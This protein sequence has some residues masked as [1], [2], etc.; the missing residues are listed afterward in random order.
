MLYVRFPLTGRKIR[1]L[2]I[3]GTYSRFSPATDPRLSYRVEDVV[4]TLE[5]VCRAIG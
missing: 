1:V 2:T 3:V 4:H 5:R